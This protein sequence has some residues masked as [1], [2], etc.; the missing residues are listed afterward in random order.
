[1]N[2]FRFETYENVVTKH[3]LGSQLDWKAGARWAFNDKLSDANT[4]VQ[5]VRQIDADTVEIVKRRDQNLGM[6][7][8]WLG[9]DQKGVFERVTINRKERTTAIDRMDANWWESTAFIGRRD[10]FYPETRG[11]AGPEQIAYVQHDFWLAKG[12]KFGVQLYSN[13]DAM[14]Y[15]RCFKS[16]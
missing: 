2:S 9:L 1:M 6:G 5:S 10:L 8:R 11:E 15:K 12:K 14:G 4:T 3:H 7:F 13:F 16:V